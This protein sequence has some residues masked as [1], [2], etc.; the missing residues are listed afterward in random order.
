MLGD[1]MTLTLC[2]ENFERARTVFAQLCKDGSKIIGVPNFEVLSQFLD[3]CIVN[4]D[5]KMGMVCIILSSNIEAS[6][7]NEFDSPHFFA[8]RI[9]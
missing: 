1:V 9:A 6:N 5:L 3:A 8:N 4:Q 7:P 2:A